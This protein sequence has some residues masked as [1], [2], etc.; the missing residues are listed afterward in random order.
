MAEFADI[1]QVPRERQHIEFGSV[2]SIVLSN[3]KAMNVD[4]IVIGSHGRHGLA[5]LLGS[6]ANAI[7]N[8]AEC[9]VLLIRASE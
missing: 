3:A 6:S 9:D 4:L 8:G 1:I 7:M 2:K 5:R